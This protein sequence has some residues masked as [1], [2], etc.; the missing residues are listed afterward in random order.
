MMQGVIPCITCFQYRG[1][2]SVPWGVFSTVEDIM[3]IV[4]G[5]L[6]PQ[7]HLNNRGLHLNKRGDRA[8]ALNLI[9]HIRD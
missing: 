8:L 1:V 6:E 4:E 9:N 3:S 5:Y 2:C 7:N